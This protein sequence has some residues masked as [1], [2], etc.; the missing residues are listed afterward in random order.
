MLYLFQ[1]IFE[2]IFHSYWITFPFICLA[3]V[4]LHVPHVEY[5]IASDIICC[6]PWH[7]HTYCFHFLDSFMFWMANTILKKSSKSFCLCIIN[8]CCS[9]SIYCNT[10]SSPLNIFSSLNLFASLLN[11]C[12][13]SLSNVID[14]KTVV[15]LAFIFSALNVFVSSLN[16]C[17]S[18]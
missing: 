2:D 8:I 16:T 13:S 18:L 14:K 9:L 15:C 1:D 3:K 6:F 12:V 11:M 10:N 4:W 5:P 17:V 7:S